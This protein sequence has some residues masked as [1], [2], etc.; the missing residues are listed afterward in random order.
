MKKNILPVLFMMLSAILRGQDISFYHL[1]TAD[2]LT[3]NQITSAAIDKN[4][5]LWIG[6]PE[7]LN[8]YDGY[9]VTQYR[10]SKYPG[11]GNNDI[12]SILCDSH[13]RLWMGSYF[14]AFYRDERKQF[15]LLQNDTTRLFGAMIL[16]TK[17]Y[18]TIISSN[19][20]H[21]YFDEKNNKWASLKWSQDSLLKI[22]WREN[23][24]FKDDQ[25]IHTGSQGDVV[26][27]D[28]A[29]RKILMRIKLKIR[30]IT[31]CRLNENEIMTADY[32]GNLARVR[33]SD[34]KILK[35]HQAV[36]NHNGK[37][38]IIRATT[39]RYIRDNLIVMGT[40]GNGLFIF[41]AEK[42]TWKQYKHDIADGKSIAG[43]HTTPV[44]ADTKGNVVVSTTA[45]LSYFNVLN[46][47]PA[48]VNY[49]RN[50]KNEIYSGPVLCMAE[51]KV[52]ETFWLGTRDRLI[53]WNRKTNQSQYYY[54]TVDPGTVNEFRVEINTL[55]MDDMGRVWAG[56]Y[57]A[58]ICI[59][60]HDGRLIRQFRFYSGADSVKTN[61][62]SSFV[63]HIRKEGNNMWAATRFGVYEIDPVSFSINMLHE[64]LPFKKLPKGNV[65]RTFADSKGNYYFY[66][67]GKGIC[68][69]SA[70]GDTAF[71][72]PKQHLVN[73]F[74]ND[75][76]EDRLGNIYMFGTKGIDVLDANGKITTFSIDKELLDERSESALNDTLG[77]IWFTNSRYMSRYD[78][79][80]KI[81]TFYDRSYGFP[82][83]GF[84]AG[85]SMKTSQG[86]F[87]FGGKQGLTSFY[88]HL[89][90]NKTGA[91]SVFVH[92]ARFPDTTIVS[93]SQPIH[94]NYKNNSIDFSFGVINIYGAERIL[95][96][97]RLEGADKNWSPPSAERNVRY[98]AIAPGKYTF[99]VKASVD[100]KTWVETT[101][102]VS[103]TIHPPFWKTWWFRL[104]AILCI[105]GTAILL[106]RYRIKRVRKQEQFKREYEKK[107]AETEMHALRAQMNPHFMFNSLNSIN[108]FI[109][110]NDPDNASGYLTK[111]SRLM[112]L[113]LDNSRS[114]WVLL[115]NEMKALSLYIELEA[116]RFDHSFAY[117]IEVTKDIDAETTMLPPLMIQPYV[118]NAIW[119]G[120]LH[121]K[122]PGGKLDIRLW[123]NND[124]LYI[125]IEDNGVGR[126]EASR[127]KSK[128]ATKQKS[129]GMKITAERMDIVNRV[130]NVE[131]GV[132]ITDI[133]QE[134]GKQ[135]GTRVLITLKYKTHDS[136]NS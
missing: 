23:V 42:E 32:L 74:V 89:L 94:R 14:E 10:K 34:G 16:E 135:N 97:Y 92:T 127:L 77:N 40:P 104:L 112:R 72:L 136:Y 8:S 80:K 39:I 25:F 69:Y 26:V 113:I 101:E 30:A 13:N 108:N 38:K 22:G 57:G 84:E 36:I 111:F 70:S 24:P 121:R 3:S 99:R 27:I 105:V 133:Q 2:G 81:F 55:A 122:E 43:D 41:D 90:V 6:T 61:F 58:G 106:F 53:K 76:R 19:I 118:E 134:D 63:P 65:T 124:R 52:P 20:G 21:L 67:Y 64:S 71:Y 79:E 5:I 75:L 120:L 115:E 107:I 109:L 15:H 31:S 29:A 86:D 1:S 129:H 103:F 87:I 119:H 37:A 95:Y 45:G 46:Y 73:Y 117:S 91:L 68:R 12:T 50:E 4:G 114:E 96:S 131:A 17:S 83:T 11:M 60:S 9:S 116:V 7:G 28:F 98:T 47:T 125:E 18:G 128:T 100:G 48:R 130:Y 66:Y 82:N 88:P 132:T 102:P 54:F 44:Y 110:K 85:T 49:F 123:K 35:E 93:F 51:S 62:P 78:P 126:Q 33:V 59:L 56:T